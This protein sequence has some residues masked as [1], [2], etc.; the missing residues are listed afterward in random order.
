MP[1]I[2][3]FAAICSYERSIAP[4]L[5]ST[6]WK[7]FD[8]RR[9]GKILDS[10]DWFRQTPRDHDPVRQ[11]FHVTRA[12]RPRLHEHADRRIGVHEHRRCVLQLIEAADRNP[13]APSAPAGRWRRHAARRSKSDRSGDAH[14]QLLPA[15]AGKWKREALKRERRAG[16]LR[17][18]LPIPFERQVLASI[19]A[20]DRS[21]AKGPS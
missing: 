7:R 13:A 11:F 21:E 12:A 10:A 9:P 18:E 17:S 3:S 19:A 8:R 20:C 1:M 4:S 16:H 5:R 14:G 15:L 6:A 2:A